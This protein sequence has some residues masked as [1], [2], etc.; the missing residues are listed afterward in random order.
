MYLS[1]S[2]RLTALLESINV[3]NF[4]DVINYIPR[5][6]EDFT[7]T[8][9]TL[10]I[11]KQKIV[12]TGTIA[13]RPIYSKLRRVSKIT[14]SFL[15][16]R[17]NHYQ[18]VA[19]NRPYLLKTLIEGDVYTI[20]GHYDSSTVSINLIAM[21]KGEV[22]E[23][24]YFRPIYSLPNGI[25]NYQFSQLVKKAFT[26][27]DNQQITDYVPKHLKQKYQLID[28]YKA[29]NTLH[30]PNKKS[31]VIAG[32]RVLKYEECYRYALKI[33][34][35]KETNKQLIKEGKKAIDTKKINEIVKKLPFRLTD[36]QKKAIQEIVL[37]MNGDNLM[38]RLLQ[39]D[40]GSGKTVIA[41]LALY[42]N[43]LRG[44][45]GA[46]MAPTDALA[47]QHY[48]TLKAIFA[49][50]DVNIAL[51][52]GSLSEKEKRTIKEFL[53]DGV[54][55]VIIG[56]HAL[57]SEDVIYQSLGLAVIDEQH[58]FGVNQRDL[59]A[60]KGKH[61]DILMMSATPI[62]RSLAMTIYADMDVTTLTTNPF[63]DRQVKTKIIDVQSSQI[64]RSI[65][66]TLSKKR[67]IYVIAPVID[68]GKKSIFAVEKLYKEYLKR[69]P[70]KVT[71]LHGRLD[72]EEKQMALNDFKN[73]VKPILVSTTVVEV[74]ID[75]RQ[76]SLMIIYDAQQF[77]LATLHQLRGR[78]GRD[79]NEAICYLLTEQ[80][81]EISLNRL[82][83]LVKSNDGFLIALEDLKQRGPG[84]LMGHRQAGIP[85][86]NYVN[87]VKDFK[88]LAL[89]I[90]DVYAC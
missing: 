26:Q 18:I 32:M 51:L 9:E 31:D 39:G 57:F 43:K 46:L 49:D 47:K 78:I 77:G 25:N 89:A 84:E 35:I 79:G 76:A 67:C 70:G 86:F 44:D 54:I 40:V 74:G 87:I 58:R 6:Y 7:P 61:A 24:N 36:D 90:K 28:K 75:V 52:V 29:L 16:K 82:D 73:G 59:L 72:E 30:F 34:K 37:D 38:Y 68:E 15:S 85:Q 21:I 17:Q 4:V 20:K 22:K 1:K 64:Y 83:I 2:L 53:L 48:Q 66:Q 88:I 42:A 33:K 10:L 23:D 81:E 19:F 80:E 3:N 55:D 13:S 8:E 56:T 71:L 5:T 14:F 11:D 65:E 27:I 50:F 41:A 62:P 12:L 45:Q 63:K 60:N 69:Y